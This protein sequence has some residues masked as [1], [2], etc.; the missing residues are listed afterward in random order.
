M[1]LHR[2]TEFSQAT[3]R[4]REYVDQFVDRA[5]AHDRDEKPSTDSEGQYVFLYELVKHTKGRT[6][7][8]DQI[9][10]VLLAGRD[11]T[12]S[13]LSITWFI[14]AR[15]PDIWKR[16]REEVSALDG[17]KPSFEDLKS[18]SYLTWVLNESQ[19]FLIFLE[20]GQEC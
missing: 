15:R 13:L 10:N 17:R 5:L 12:A 11:T 6:E 14:L 3:A 9:L 16:L 1:F 20:F 18:L 19:Y 7:L 2:D 8:R 4:A